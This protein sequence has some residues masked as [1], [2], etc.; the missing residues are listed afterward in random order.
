M[1]RSPVLESTVQEPTTNQEPDFEMGA[2][3]PPPAA[4]PHTF[5]T[6]TRPI[7]ITRTVATISHDRRSPV[8]RPEQ[9]TEVEMRV[10]S[11]TPI[12]PRTLTT[13]TTMNGIPNTQ[14]VET[15]STLVESAVKVRGE[16]WRGS[17]QTSF[18][19]FPS[20][21]SNALHVP[22]MLPT[23]SASPDTVVE[24]EQKPEE[25]CQPPNNCN[26][27]IP[28]AA[29]AAMRHFPV[30]S[31]QSSLIYN[32]SPALLES[33]YLP[34]VAFQPFRLPDIANPIEAN[35]IPGL[36]VAAPT[37]GDQSRP[38]LA[39]MASREK[40][41]PGL[42]WRRSAT[43]GWR[44]Y[45]EPRIRPQPTHRERQRQIKL[46]KEAE[47]R[48]QRL[49]WEEPI[50][51]KR[52][53]NWDMDRL[54]QLRLSEQPCNAKAKK[55][56]R[57]PLKRPLE[58]VPDEEDDEERLRVIRRRCEPVEAPSTET[59][60]STDGKEEAEVFEEKEQR[61]RWL[62]SLRRIDITLAPRTKQI[63]KVGLWYGMVFSY[64]Y[65]R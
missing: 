41:A 56:A 33:T 53:I 7:A 6:P 64:F 19:P 36:P 20:F 13:D 24:Q 2:T 3:S 50:K 11:L 15:A 34:Q 5:T 63:I 1:R 14:P 16:Q 18:I 37:I 48:V 54:L 61:Q 29:L 44:R 10:V 22:L 26:A 45:K 17:H 57:S 23:S 39:T 25:D 59:E 47:A 49:T 12:S 55:R 4:R 51:P 58:T 60:S 46:R 8:G 52:I 62:P 38:S 31:V 28:G 21:A 65:T 30:Q 9:Q 27:A 32:P 43:Q 35:A 42:Q 40:K